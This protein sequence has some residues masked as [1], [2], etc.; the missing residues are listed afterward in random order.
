MSLPY[1]KNINIMFK[2]LKYLQNFRIIQLPIVVRRE[3]FINFYLWCLLHAMNRS[4]RKLMNR[5]FYT[6]CCNVYTYSAFMVMLSPKLPKTIWDSLSGVK[7]IYLLKSAFYVVNLLLCKI[8]VV[9]TC[10][11]CSAREFVHWR[12][13]KC[14]CACLFIYVACIAHELWCCTVLFSTLLYSTAGWAE[15]LIHL[16]WSELPAP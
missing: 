10:T 2:M 15:I 9:C 4:C 7:K 13:W 12:E 16:S 3:L 11:E 1:I 14:C 8:V 6:I 5:T